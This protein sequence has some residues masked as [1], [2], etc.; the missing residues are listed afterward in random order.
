MIR[1]IL[2][3]LDGVIRIWNAEHDAHVEGNF[4]LPAGA[5]R[6]A[7]FAPELLQPVITGRIAD[8]VWR[9]Q[10]AARLQQEHPIIDAAVVVQRWSAS[11]GAVDHA[12]LDL[13]QRCR[14]T[15]QVALI[16]NATSRLMDD[17]R[18][19]AIDTAFDHIINSSQVGWVKPQAE[20]FNVA[21]QQV[22]VSAAETLFIDDRPEHVVAAVELGM[23]G[24][25]YTGVEP[26]RQELAAQRIL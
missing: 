14:Q 10:I 9:Q 20:I 12:V 21:L 19:L 11:S 24:R 15:V 5:L 23:A 16:T 18:R 6:R 25:A 17:L 7:A 3:D 13:I 8:E 4:G 1:A 22:G 26:L 2:V